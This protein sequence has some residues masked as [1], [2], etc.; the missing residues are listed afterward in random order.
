[1][2]GNFNCSFNNLTSLEGAP[3]I[4]GGNFDC[5]FNKKLKSLEGCPK[6]VGGDFY[7]SGPFTEEDIRKVCNVKGRVMLKAE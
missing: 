5:A 3:E 1:M 7:Y 2:V 6:E 4:V